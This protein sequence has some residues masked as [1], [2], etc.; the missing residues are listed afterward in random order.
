VQRGVA[1]IPFRPIHLRRISF[2]LNAMQNSGVSFIFSK[3]S[4]SFIFFK[5]QPS[6]LDFYPKRT[7]LL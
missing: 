4:I 3:T 1:D 6:E 2:R 5:N 7:E